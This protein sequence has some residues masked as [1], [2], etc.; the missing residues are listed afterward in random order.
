MIKEFEIQDILN[1]VNSISKNKKM[2][3][4]VVEK[5]YLNDEN[6]VLNHNNQVKSNKSEVLVL[7]Q[8]IE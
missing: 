7:D 4:T 8:M 2:N 3:V 1:A 6:Q 5:K